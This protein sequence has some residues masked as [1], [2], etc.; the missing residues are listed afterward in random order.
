MSSSPEELQPGNW[1]PYSERPEWA[2]IAP[3][4]QDDGPS[5]V[6]Q[7]AYTDRFKDVYDF[8]RA[9]LKSGEKSERVL[10]LT[11]DALELNPANYTVWHYRR[12]V[13]KAIDADL[14]AELKYCRDIIED[15]PKNYQVWQHRRVLVEWLND[16]GSELRFT[17]LILAQDQKNYHAWQHRQWVLAT[18]NL[19]EDELVFVDRLLTD[20]IRNNS[21]WNQRFFV[22]SRTGGWGRELVE[23]EVKFSLEK[24]QLVRRNESAWNYLRGVLDACTDSECAKEQREL[25][26]NKCRVLLAEGCDSPY[27]LG[28]LVELLQ[29]RLEG[30][31]DDAQVSKMV[32][33]AEE[34]CKR[35]ATELDVIRARYW[36]FIQNTISKKYGRSD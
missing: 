22:N 20:D 5:P 6:V 27:L 1:I 34:L 16:S 24:I 12:E 14:N 21:A 3:L 30:E 2:D 19:F 32:S 15:H 23:K 33:E 28:F 29:W 17:E 11:E 35:L 18:F 9:V 26:D 13:L 10:A 8:F 25:V 31:K 7:I 36:T 4:P